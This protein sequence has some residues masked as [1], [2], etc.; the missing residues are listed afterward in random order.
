VALSLRSARGGGTDTGRPIAGALGLTC[1]ERERAAA[2][3]NGSE[4]E[5]LTSGTGGGDY[6][7]AAFEPELGDAVLLT[8]FHGDKV[9]ERAVPPSSVLKRGDPS[10]ASIADFRLRV[11][12]L[13]VPVPFIGACRH[14][15]IH[16]ISNSAEMRPFS[17]GGDYD[18]PICRRILEEAGIPREL[19]GQRKQAIATHFSR[20]MRLISPETRAAFER[21]L[22]DKGVLDEVR[23]DLFVFQAGRAVF[24]WV[25][26]AIKIAPVLEWSLG[27]LRDCLD[28]QFRA[29]EN[30]RYSNLLFVWALEQ[31]VAGTQR[32][33]RHPMQ[34]EF[35]GSVSGAMLFV[36]TCIFQ[37]FL[38]L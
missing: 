7:L 15:E 17:V 25:R 28:G 24:R 30:S 29:R 35:R 22:R 3:Q 36:N 38:I 1:V 18:R 5:W 34:H 37:A 19:V 6:P 11:G 31:V 32:R 4:L 10:G 27:W 8:G 23:R 26:K 33:R 21:D 2:A 16:T 13:H 12:F 14:S 9:W 20:N